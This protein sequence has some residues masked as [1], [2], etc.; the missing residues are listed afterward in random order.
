MWMGIPAVVNIV[1][2]VNEQTGTKYVAAVT[3]TGIGFG[4]NLYYAWEEGYTGWFT[5]AE[6]IQVVV[7]SG[8]PDFVMKEFKHTESSQNSYITI[9]ITYL[10]GD[11]EKIIS[12]T[13]YVNEYGE[14]H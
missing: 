8:N 1:R 14:V 3:D 12:Q 4:I 11:V 7:L 5:G 6:L 2:S 10:Y 13:Y 9:T